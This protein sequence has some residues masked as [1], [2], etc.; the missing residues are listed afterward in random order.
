M[1]PSRWARYGTVKVLVRPPVSSE[2]WWGS[3]QD[4]ESFRRSSSE[5]SF[6]KNSTASLFF[7]T[8]T[9]EHRRFDCSPSPSDCDS[10][11]F[12]FQSLTQSTNAIRWESGDQY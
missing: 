6:S 5:Q 11:L 10:A 4:M 9:S 12:A 8:T 1:Y 2:S 7:E 3:I